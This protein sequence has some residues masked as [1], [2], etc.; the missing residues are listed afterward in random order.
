MTYLLPGMITMESAEDVADFL[1]ILFNLLC[2]LS[3]G[4]PQPLAWL[5]EKRLVGTMVGMSRAQRDVH[6]KAQGF[7]SKVLEFACHET[8]FLWMAEYSISK[9]P[10]IG[11]GTRL[12]R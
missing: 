8:L 12:F 5:Q 7:A 6:G 4:N 10:K 3:S 2:V 9:L 11:Y 1:D